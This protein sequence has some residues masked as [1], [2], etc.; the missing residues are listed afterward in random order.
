MNRES[1]AFGCGAVHFAVRCY[2]LDPTNR[3]VPCACFQAIHRPEPM[4]VHK[5]R[6]TRTPWDPVL[7]Q[8]T[9]ATSPASQAGS[10][11]NCSR[12]LAA[13]RFEV[14]DD[15][16]APLLGQSGPRRHAAPKIPVAQKPFKFARRGILNGGEMQ[17]H[18]VALSAGVRAVTFGAMLAKQLLARQDGIG[19]AFVRIA[20]LASSLG[21]LRDGE[22][23][24]AIVGRVLVAVLVILLGSGASKGK[25]QCQNE[26]AGYDPSRHRSHRNKL[27]TLWPKPS[28]S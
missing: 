20:P 17:V 3:W 12:E 23:N 15:L 22:Q 13:Q 25:R 24:A 28:I 16:P 19:L 9:I 6:T 10:A 8:K 2:V 5:G 27:L 1:V 7:V 4:D 14:G 18:R 11:I 26:Q 21:R